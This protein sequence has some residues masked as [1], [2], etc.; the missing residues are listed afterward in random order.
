MDDFVEQTSAYFDKMLSG[1]LAK[2]LS[3]GEYK[4]GRINYKSRQRYAKS[5][6][7]QKQRSKI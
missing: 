7:E 3:D 2:K 5:K 4:K 1:S 6:R